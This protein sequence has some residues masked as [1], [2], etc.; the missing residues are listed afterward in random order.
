VPLGF[1][2]Q[3]E[4]GCFVLIRAGFRQPPALPRRGAREEYRFHQDS[5]QSTRI[6]S[7]GDINL[8]SVGAFV[9]K[10]RAAQAE[11]NLDSA[12]AQEGEA[13]IRTLE[14]A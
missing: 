9:E 1:R 7:T 3:R 14:A 4:G 5:D 6:A 10:L 13:E 11:L 2:C 12:V 8:G